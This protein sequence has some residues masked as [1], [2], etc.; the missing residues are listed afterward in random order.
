M[1]RVVSDVEDSVSAVQEVGHAQVAVKA[2]VLV[3]GRGKAGGI[4]LVEKA[5]APEAVKAML[6]TELKGEK[7]SEVLIEEKLNIDCEYYLSLTVNRSDKNVTFLFSEEGGVEIEE[8]A[9]VSP[10]KIIRV[11]IVGEFP[12]ELVQAAMESNA[13]ASQIVALA[14]KMFALMKEKDAE[15]VEIN[16]LVVS[17]GQLIAADAKVIIDDNALYKH[18]EFA[19]LKERE[20]SEL[21]KKSR[22]FNLNYVELD[23][24]IAIIGNGAGLVMATLDIV[25][26]FGGTPANFLDIGGGA[27]V[28][29]M[30]KAV[31]IVLEKKPKG[32]W[33]NIFGGITKCD[34]VA[35]GLANYA[36]ERGISIPIV[37]R[38]IGTNEAEG[39]K[40]L[41]ENGIR[42]LDSMELCAKKIVELAKR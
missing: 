3:G 20:L 6:G 22:E 26:H 10:E 24:D 35:R 5:E 37:V 39:K 41:E 18:E 8:L 31:E 40:I 34:E 32:I 13:H 33:I 11:G 17:S 15:L 16:P 12:R 2:Q 27:N 28:E 7:I 30:Q 25:Q 9:K 14:E 4:K 42:S 21:E 19:R 29:Q 36:N 1:G 38:M 23:G